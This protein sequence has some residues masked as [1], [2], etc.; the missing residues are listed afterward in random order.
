MGSRYTFHYATSCV[1][2][3]VEY[4]G[5]EKSEIGTVLRFSTSEFGVLAAGSAG[6]CFN[7]VGEDLVSILIAVWEFNVNLRVA[8]RCDSR[9]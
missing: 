6:C 2:V 5:A 7:P 4:S 3:Y 9:F 1:Y 8:F